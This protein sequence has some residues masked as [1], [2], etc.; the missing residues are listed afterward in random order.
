MIK[1]NIVGSIEEFDFSVEK[2]TKKILKKTY[3]ILKKELNLKKHIASY[4]YV[5][6]EEIHR[7]NKEYRDID[8]PTDVISFAYVDDSSEEEIPLELGDVFICKEKVFEQSSE[9]NHSVLR[10]CAFLITHG[11]LHLL[12]FDHMNKEDETVMF[13]LQD[14]ILNELKIER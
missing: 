11:I 4:I 5:D 1:F 2:L 6:L 7:I 12:G 9:Y 8:R 3:K 13:G 14:K 10:E